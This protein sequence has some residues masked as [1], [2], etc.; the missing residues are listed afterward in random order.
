M[1]YFVLQ[2]PSKEYLTHFTPLTGGSK[3]IKHKQI[4]VI[5][6]NNLTPC[7]KVASCDSTNVNTGRRGGVIAL[8]EQYL[9]HRLLFG[10]HACFF[11]FHALREVKIFGGRNLENLCNS[12]YF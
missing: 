12:D 7:M 4:D 6:E 3:D 2:L 8:L 5:K 10:F 9:G 1:Y 11:G